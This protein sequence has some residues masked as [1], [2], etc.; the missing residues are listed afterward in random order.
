EKSWLPDE[1]RLPLSAAMTP[2]RWAQLSPFL[3][4]ALDQSPEERSR[5]I[6]R[7]A[8]NDP[9]LRAD[10]ERLLYECSRNDSLIDRGAAERFAL[11]FDEKV[12]ELRGVLGERFVVEREIGRGGMATVFLAH[13]RKHQRPVAIKVLRREVA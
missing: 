6:E 3:D 11:L 2:E 13:D 7:V 5:Y 12:A 9:G 4:A 10:L 8:E 1:V